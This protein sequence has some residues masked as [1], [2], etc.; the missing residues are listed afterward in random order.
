MSYIREILTR[1]FLARLPAH[2]ACTMEVESVASPIVLYRA[3]GSIFWSDTIP[4][5]WPTPLAA[6]QEGAHVWSCYNPA[7][8]LEKQ[9]TDAFAVAF[10]FHPK[11]AQRVKREA[12]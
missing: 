4:C 3:D 6:W 7:D 10:E 1:E 11:G 9:R 2:C 8:P 5:P 12:A